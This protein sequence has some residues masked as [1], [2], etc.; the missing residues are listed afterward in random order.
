M[1]E[2]MQ[3]RAETSLG[4]FR[5]LRYRNARIFFIGLLVSNVGTWLQFTATSL[6]LYQLTGKATNIGVNVMFQFLPMLL[7]GAWAGGVADRRNRRLLTIMTQAGM[8]IQAFALGIMQL[9]GHVSVGAVYAAS[10]SLGII[11]AI[12]NPARR[13]LVTELVQSIDIGN[14]LSLNTAVMTG[15][16]IFGP[17]LAATLAGPLGIGA[18]FLLNGCSFLAILI[19][20][21]LIDPRKLIA[22]HHASKGGRPVREAFDFVRSDRSLFITFLVF[23]IVS[24]FAF[25]FSVVLPKL[26]DQ[27]W[28]HP[29]AFGWL[30]ATTSIGS[31]IG[32]LLIARLATVSIQWFSAGV[33]LMGVSC[34]SVAWSPNI[35]FAFVVAIPLGLGG[36]SVVAS[37]N[38][39]S[40]QKSPED[41]RSRLLALVAVG[42]LGSTPIGGPITGWIADNVSN[43]WALG[44]G[45]VIA[46]ASLPL[47]RL[48]KR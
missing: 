4:M 40:Q 43:E 28:G 46:L 27:R 31:L 23:T 39:I 22:P 8:T 16:R 41:M 48:V 7:L 6:L 19:S 24:T 45:G 11:S 38:A 20:L 30:L 34:I 33:A 3:Q 17:A 21:F 2:K 13:G 12:D 36:T 5:S 47:M 26:C 37:M 15:S 1:T 29:G 10:L 42:F 32:S 18:L 25:N 9:T 44:Y 14:A 35:F